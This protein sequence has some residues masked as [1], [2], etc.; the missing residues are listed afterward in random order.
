MDLIYCNE[1]GEDLGVLRNFQLD[2]AFGN[3][4][5]DFLLTLN[6]N[7]FTLKKDYVI[8]IENSEIWGII[9]GFKLNTKSNKISYY[10]RTWQGVLN[11][12]VLEPTPNKDYLTYSGEIHNLL[13]V[14]INR[15]RLSRF[16]EVSENHRTFNF[17]NYKMDRYVYIY[18]GINKM[19][20][21]KNLKFKTLFQNGKVVLEV[22]DAVDYSN[23][24]FDSS[25]VN[26]SVELK[27]NIPNHIIALGKGEL[28]DRVVKHIYYDENKKQIESQKFFGE[29][30]IIYIYDY[31]NAE[32]E[33][34]L[35]KGANE[36][37]KKLKD[38]DIKITLNE[39]KLY[40]INDK[41]SARETT[42]NTYIEKYIV[43]KIIKMTEKEI[44]INYEVGD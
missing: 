4:E 24:E 11:S 20:K 13:K 22:V 32:S 28:K 27:E 35:I 31:A 40:D 36:Y 37:M 26:F 14:V 15:F 3:S 18:N 39:E 2:F 5:N 17:S 1:N 44:K 43:K 10:G 19:L 29:K 21:S 16:F 41:I 12:K 7:E 30:E 23:D 6:L 9:D 8:Y 33:E 34:E 38:S 25:Q 42:T